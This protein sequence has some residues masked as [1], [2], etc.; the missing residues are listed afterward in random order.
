MIDIDARPALFYVPNAAGLLGPS[1][2]NAL[3]SLELCTTYR[4][5]NDV[6]R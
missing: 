2:S 5:D 3:P 1:R 4:G 6:E